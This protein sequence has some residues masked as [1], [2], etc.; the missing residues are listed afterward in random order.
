MNHLCDVCG[1]RPATAQ[2]T[3]VRN[4][5]QQI[6]HLCAIDFAH[7]EQQTGSVLTPS[8]EGVDLSQFLSEQS[9]Q[10]FQRA[11]E[12]AGSNHRSEVDTEHLLGALLL[13][14]V[15][16][17][18]LARLK[19]KPELLAERLP[20]TQGG[21]QLPEGQYTLGITPRLKRVV[22]LSLRASQQ[23]GHKYVGPEH[24]LIGLLEEGEGLAAAALQAVGV[25]PTALRQ[26][27]QKVVGAGAEDGKVASESSTP[28]LD[29]YGRDLSELAKEGKLD[30]VIG[31]ASEIESTIEILARRTKNNPALIGEPGVGKTAIVEGLVQ[32]ILAGEVPEPLQGKR[33]VELSINGMVA[34]SRYRGDFEERLQALLKEVTEHKDELI[35]FVDEVH[36]I[37]G[38]GQGGG[39]GGLD[40]ANVMK[41]ALARGDLHLIGATTLAEY[42]KYI[43]KDAALERRF[44]PVQVPEPSVPDTIQILRGLR[45]KYEAFHRVK[46][47]DEAL[48][49]AASLSDRYITSR[50]LPDKAIDLIDQAASRTRIALTSQ[51]EEM[52]ELHQQLSVVQRELA[53]ARNHKRVD[54]ATQLELSRIELQAQ[55]EAAEAAWR[56]EKGV[57]SPEVTSEQIAHIVAKL[58]G[59]PV[60][61]LTQEERERLVHLE[62]R[63]HQRVVGQDEAVQAVA[64]AVRRSRAGLA[65][66]NRPLATMLFLGPTGVGKT[67][68][69][70]ALAATVYGDESAI[71]RIDMS[72]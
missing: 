52:R 19:L 49:A 18:V 5:R 53:E 71:I 56:H 22:E 63:L 31:R 65:E 59:V 21:A 29:K 54:E 68:L 11:A 2:V 55:Y 15:V 3:V 45:D 8:Q 23:L 64:D 14:E 35:L 43:E 34:G 32:R 66:H 40:I 41:P 39:E 47:S 26:Q 12:I 9:K 69:A 60:A 13:S 62:Q 30:P 4:G 44:Q 67:E 57:S 24:L 58:T 28:T 10:A 37:V 51:S 1:F 25:T 36:T 50:F 72:E 38:A 61:E 16:V 6:L 27:V 20:S 42:Q 46:I 48:V 7:F 17:Q 70:K 33:V